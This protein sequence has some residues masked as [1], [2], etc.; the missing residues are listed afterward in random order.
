M[1][2]PKPIDTSHVR[3][4]QGVAKLVERLAEHTHDIWAQQRMSE[5]WRFG[6]QRDDDKKLHPDLVPYA[7]L[8]E[9]EK[10]Y[11]RKTAIGFLKTVVALGYRVVR[12]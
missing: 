1:Y 2:R 9:S 8:P 12:V 5:G 10:A 6:P 3:L 7:D 11:D 4:P